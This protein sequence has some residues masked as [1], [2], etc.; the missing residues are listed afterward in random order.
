MPPCF[1]SL[2][3][4]PLAHPR[5]ILGSCQAARAFGG[6][7]YNINGILGPRSLLFGSLDP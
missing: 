3:K 1:Y 6:C 2:V 4:E 7:S 5:V